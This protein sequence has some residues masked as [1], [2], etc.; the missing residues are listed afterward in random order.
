[1]FTKKSYIPIGERLRASGSSRLD[2]TGW[3]K[4]RETSFGDEFGVLLGCV[5][6]VNRRRISGNNR[7]SR[8]LWGL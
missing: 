5:G 3:E 2:F 6:N 7:V 4:F 8:M 1:M